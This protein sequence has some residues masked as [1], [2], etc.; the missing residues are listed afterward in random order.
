ML[1][2]QYV[3]KSEV[4]EQERTV[5]AVI[6]TGAIDRDNEILLPKGADF[7]QYMKNPVVLWAHGYRDTP[8]AKALW[9]KKTW[10]NIKAKLQFADTPQA[11]EIY[12]LF[13][14]G[15]LKAFSVGFRPI[16]SHRPDEKEIAK[17]PEWAGVWLIY[18][19]WELLEFSAVPVPANP[20][21]LAIAVKSH[22]VTLSK[23]LLSDFDELEEEIHIADTEPVKS[24]PIKKPVEVKTV[25]TPVSIINTPV[26]TI[27]VPKIQRIE[28]PVRIV[29]DHNQII[30]DEM[31]KRLGKVY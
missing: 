29:P 4:D 11:E 30:E 15:F 10:K 9:I 28:V 14:G 23:E 8:I 27:L 6:S 19:E 20:E 5:T 22:D 13:K 16:K 12:Q 26:K 7:E 2:K 31:K 1:R 3:C 21:A 25:N 24:E 17:N 18:D